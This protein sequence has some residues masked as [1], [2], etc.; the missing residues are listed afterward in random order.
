[1]RTLLLLVL[2]ASIAAAEAVRLT[3]GAVLEVDSYSVDGD[4]VFLQFRQRILI[5]N[6]SEVAGFG[7]AAKPPAPPAAVTPRT[8]PSDSVAELIGQAAERH[9]VPPTLVHAIAEAESH[10]RQ[11]ARSVSGAIGVMQ[12]MPDTARALGA[13]PYDTG[14]NIDAGTR[15]LSYL[16]A[17]YRGEPN[18]LSLAL[19]AYNAGPTAVDRFGGIPPYEETQRYVQKVTRRYQQ[20]QG[21]AR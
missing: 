2:A 10:Y 3:N 12:L 4:A 20:L 1:M 11:N 15:F 19:A 13:N 5:L 7:E 18:Q 14:Q 9:G 21:H 8:L 16:L 17:R 6:R